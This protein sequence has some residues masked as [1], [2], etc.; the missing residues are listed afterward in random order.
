MAMNK[1]PGHN[2]YIGG[3]ICLKNKAAFNRADITHVL[4]VLRLNQAEIEPTFG[5]YQHHSIDVDDVDDEN[6]LEHFPA[7]I[8]FIQSGLNTGGGVLVHCAMGKSRSAA[9]C[10]A[11]LLHQQRSALTPQSA[12]TIVKECR[13]L[14]EPNDGFM[15]QLA[16]YHEMG[17]PDEFTD[18]PL[19]Q[20]WLYRRE[21]EGSVACGR[22]PE[23]KS[24]RFE[25]EQPIRSQENDGQTVEI[26]CRKC[27]RTLATSPFIIPHEEETRNKNKTFS[28]TECA[29][30]FL[31]PL[32]WMQPSL[33]PSSDENGGDAP[34]S[35]RLTCPNAT[36]GA[37]IGK[38]A[39][40]GM[41]CSCTNWV[42]PA[43]AIVKARVDIA[44]RRSAPGQGNTRPAALG[45][46]MPP[47]MRQDSG[48]GRG[49]L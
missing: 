47:G 11:Y 16:L 46:R 37:N 8:K 17:C 34:L 44:N 4:S 9:I 21:V 42:V 15:E 29:H 35:G 49:S 43:I 38:F 41:Q 25:D 10:V 20:R 7:A 27:R 2:I 28:T 26:K 40:Q 24:V 31:H 1:I 30:V 13:P 3:I 5:S 48:S 23:M 36:C 14:C 32:K 33:F 19:Y 6:L 45:I 39:W 18:D 22:A 12:L